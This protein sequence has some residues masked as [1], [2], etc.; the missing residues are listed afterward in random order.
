MRDEDGDLYA[1]N[2]FRIYLDGRTCFDF[3]A[4]G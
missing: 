3:R 1:F 4:V 2:D